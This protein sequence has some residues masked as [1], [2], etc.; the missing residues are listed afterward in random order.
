MEGWKKPHRPGPLQLCS[1]SQ[2]FAWRKEEPPPP[3]QSLTNKRGP[4]KQPF[5][6]TPLWWL[7]GPAWP[8]LE[9]TTV[10][11]KAAKKPTTL[12][13]VDLARG[14]WDEANNDQHSSWRIL[15]HS[16]RQCTAAAIATLPTSRQSEATQ[17]AK[18]F[19]GYRRA[20][21]ILA[22]PSSLPFRGVPP[23]AS[24][25][26]QPRWERVDTGCAGDEMYVPFRSPA[27]RAQ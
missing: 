18:R 5:R 21:T 25:L 23:V 10:P 3:G 11:H 22:E 16:K 13:Q 17:D 7:S 24:P 27:K 14:L 8:W 6:E 2:L 26:G 15:H 12:A 20:A 4:Q 19:G 9:E 1:S